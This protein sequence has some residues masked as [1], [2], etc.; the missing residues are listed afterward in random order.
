MSSP[1]RRANSVIAR[2]ETVPL[3]GDE[4]VSLPGLAFASA[5][6]SRT[7]RALELAFSSVAP[8][9]VA[10]HAEDRWWFH[11]TG[12]RPSI[13]STARSDLLALDRPGTVVSFEGELGLADRA[14]LPWFQ[15]GRRLGERWRIE[16]EYFSLR[17]SGSRTASRDIAWD[18][19]VFP[20]SAPLSSIFDSD[21]MRLSAGYSFVQ[22]PDAEL[23]AVLGLHATRFRVS[24]ASQ[25]AIGG[26]S[27]AGQAKAEEALVPL[28]TI[29][30]YGRY[31]LAPAWV[32]SGR[33]DY[34]SFSTGRYGGGLV[35]ATIDIGW[36]A[37]ERITLSAGFRTVDYTLD[38]DRSNWRGGVDYRFKGPFVSLKFGF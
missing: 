15:A 8:V 30:L 11:V 3:R 36:R 19:T 31:D 23:G 12:Y 2:C 9:A 20:A 18:D 32:V 6:T 7:V 4:K 24:L 29:G 33:F 38:I 26:F 27:G 28:P 17:R 25:V 22:R 35:D 21:V 14:T 34:F 5:T 1:A 16:L 37:N 10:Q 13:D